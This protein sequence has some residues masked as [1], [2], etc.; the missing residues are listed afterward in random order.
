MSLENIDE[1]SH[2]HSNWRDHF[3]LVVMNDDTHEETA[4]YRLTRMNIY[5]FVSAVVV[6]LVILTSL[7]IASTPLRYYIPG[8]GDVGL[9]RKVN[10]LTRS[11][12]SLEQHLS[13]R[14]VYIDNISKILRE[15]FV[16][17]KDSAAL[18]N[19]NTDSLMSQYEVPMEDSSMTWLKMEIE[20]EKAFGSLSQTTIGGEGN[21]HNMYFFSPIS[22]GVVKT[23]FN[24]EKNAFG[25]SVAAPK[26]AEI[27]CVL[28]GMVI[29]ATWT[30]N[31]GNIIAVQHKNNLISFYKHNSLLLKK[32]GNFV[33]AGEAIAIIGQK[34]ANIDAYELLF[35][36]WHSG[37]PTNPKDYIKL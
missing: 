28:D 22:N 1:G 23:E 19:Q 30:P 20:A 17:E 35:E 37:H 9:N 10:K 8:Y 4:S 25:V 11:V 3:R 29:T 18:A 21:I 36:L 6:G 34:N 7:I 33:K 14:Q 15:D 12:D 16:T 31:E 24:P 26:D 2:R 5:M 32:V 13:E 27:K